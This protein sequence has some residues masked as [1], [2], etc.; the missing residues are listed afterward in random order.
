MATWG[1]DT[2]MYANGYNITTFFKTA[3]VEM[4]CDLSD[5]TTFG[6]EAYEFLRGLKYATGTGEG[7]YDPINTDPDYGSATVL[8]AVFNAAGGLLLYSFVPIGDA[9]GNPVYCVYGPVNS[10]G[11]SIDM[12]EAVPLA[13]AV[14]S[15]IGAK[16]HISHKAMGAVTATGN[17]TAVNN[18]A[19]TTTG[20]SAAL[21]VTVVSGT[22]PTLD[23]KIQHS[24][25]NSV[26]ADLLTLAQVTTDNQ[27]EYKTVTGTVNQYT[28]EVHTVGGTG[29]PSFTYYIGF[30]RG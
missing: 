8:Y 28:R 29:S 11:V 4:G 6:D 22:N 15:N 3:G 23:V 7:F 14:E 16:R 21:H 5:I 26:W 2:K 27:S 18:G 1:K 12:T 25:D 19:A 20:G 30:G 17:G 10:Y 13:F 9:H 24:E